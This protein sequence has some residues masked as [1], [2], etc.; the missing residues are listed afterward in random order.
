[1]DKKLFRHLIITAIALLLTGCSL[2]IKPRPVSLSDPRFNGMFSYY[3][4]REG[5]SSSDGYWYESYTFDGTNKAINYTEYWYWSGYSW[6]Y[7]GDYK[8]DYYL[9]E[10]EIEINSTK[11]A[12][13]HRLWDNEFS[14]WS[15][16]KP[17]Q[18]LDNGDTLVIDGDVYTKY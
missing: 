15:E 3:E 7:S 10:Y 4:S 14:T 8:G 18:F 17:Y 1:M 12:L 13:R 2:T 11:T 5:W 16:W 9:F 6:H